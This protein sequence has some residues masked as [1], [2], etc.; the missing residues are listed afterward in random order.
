MNGRPRTEPQVTAAN[1]AAAPTIGQ[2]LDVVL[3]NVVKPSG[4]LAKH[5]NIGRDLTVGLIYAGL[6]AGIRLNEIKVSEAATITDLIKLV[7]DKLGEWL[8]ARIEA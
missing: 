5:L 1:A 8:K 6:A 2:A 7:D 4:D 3:A